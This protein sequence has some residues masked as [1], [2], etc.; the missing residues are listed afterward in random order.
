[1]RVG[2]SR[3][4][5]AASA[6]LSGV[7]VVLADRSVQHQHDRG[8]QL[9]LG[10]RQYAR[11]RRS[12]GATR[13][14]GAAVRANSRRSGD[15]AGAGHRTRRSCRC[16]CAASLYRRYLQLARRHYACRSGLRTSTS[17]SSSSTVLSGRSPTHCVVVTHT[18]ELDFV[19]G[20][21]F[22]LFLVDSRS[23]C[24]GVASEM[25]ACEFDGSR[26]RFPLSCRAEEG[27]NRS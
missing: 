21:L 4:R 20:R 13:T 8:G 14:D 5:S 27:Q 17:V 7:P 11:R 22:L 15:S 24:V 6:T 1:M 2:R 10:G 16:A 19:P 9:R 25:A 26:C 3:A 23:V 18:R 12:R